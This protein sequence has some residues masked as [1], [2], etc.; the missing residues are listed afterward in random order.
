MACRDFADERAILGMLQCF[1]GRNPKD[2]QG[3]V[4]AM[5][6]GLFSSIAPFQTVEK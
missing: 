3:E 1:A 6:P 5:G 2:C 4:S